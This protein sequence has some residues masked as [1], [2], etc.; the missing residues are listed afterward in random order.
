MPT[1]PPVHRP[2]GWRPPAQIKAEADRKRPT[3][4]ARGYDEAWRA[5]RAKILRERP[6]CERPGCSSTDRLN[7]HHKVSIR[8][9]PERR[10]D[11]TNLQVLCARCHSR[12]TAV[13]DSRL[14]RRTE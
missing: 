14:G 13:L 4:A 7:V 3:P 5:L 8:K 1:R 6:W 12:V 9:A 10:L 11:R 2:T